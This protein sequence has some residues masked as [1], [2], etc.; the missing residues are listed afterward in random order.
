[1]A[2]LELANHV[3]TE[4]AFAFRVSEDGSRLLAVWQPGSESPV[5]DIGAVRGLL[6]TH[7]LG[8]FYL[9]E[10]AVTLLLEASET[11]TERVELQ[12]GE[13][14]DGAAVITVSDDKLEARLTL[15]PAYGGAAVADA[16]IREALQHAHVSS[17]ILDEAIAGALSAGFAADLV[18]ARGRAAEHG[19]D[20]S[21]VSL[22]PAQARGPKVDEHGVTDYRNLGS[23]SGVA[24]GDPVMR[25]IVA[26][27][28]TDGYD[29]TG[30]VLRAKAGKSVAYA[31]RLKGVTP[32][33]EDADLLRAAIAGRP[34]I[35]PNG[36]TVEPTI[37]VQEVD[38]STGNI[39]FA[40]SVTVLGDV[41]ALMK[42]R[43]TGDVLVHGTVAAADIEAGG[44]VDLKGGF[45][46]ALEE[47]SKVGQGPTREFKIRCAGSFHARFVEYA[48][49][50]SG[51]DIVIDDHSMFSTL[52]AARRV[53]V[54]GSG[55][56]KGQILGGTVWA[57]EQV[58]ATIFGAP[59]GSK[60]SVQVGFESKP[61]VRQSQLDVEVGKHEARCAELRQMISAG[62]DVMKWRRAGLVEPP[63]RVLVTVTEELERLRADLAHLKAQME[64][65]A[66]ARVVVGRT[67]Y[68]GTQIRIGSKRWISKDDHASGVFRVI[69]GEVTLHSS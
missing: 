1:M 31:P 48:H 18:V 10:A 43:A 25:R 66:R 34:V 62:S 47:G 41:M 28:G 33:A 58:T 27:K 6:T 69:D 8:D 15:Q 59:T 19:T 42:I 5:L 11:S 36:M 2:P 56:G 65:S 60:T 45:K 3:M 52:S 40:G 13:R 23:I 9:D 63:E 51:G 39:D 57:I 35:A 32:D 53:T 29:V 38:M 37:D 7:G 30:V 24:A 67:V 21:F 17:G 12:I 55:A 61:V 68:A 4:E 54:G 14:R 16:G 26:T 46:G 44:N 50:E 64:L 20:T 49:V 22:V